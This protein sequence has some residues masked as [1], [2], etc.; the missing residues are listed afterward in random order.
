VLGDEQARGDLVR[1]EVLVEEQQYL[2]L[3]RGEARRDLVGNAATD[4]APLAH[5]LEQ[6]ARH[7]A[8]ERRLTVGDAVQEGCDALG[9][10]AL[11]QVTRCSCADRRQEVFLRSGRR[12]YDD[13]ARRCSVA[14][15]G[16]GGQAVGAGHRQVEQHEVG[17]ERPRLVDRLT[18]VFCVAGDLEAVL[19]Q[20]R[21]ERLPRQRVIVDDQDARGH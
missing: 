15:A 18:A 8:R 9:G 7:G 6:R 17:G 14:D 12:Q 21:R 11:E 4:P 10:L 5:P 19:L 1:R 2:E 20:Q 13:L 3:A 16:K